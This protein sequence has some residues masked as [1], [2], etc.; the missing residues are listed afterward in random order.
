MAE[1]TVVDLNPIT[2][3]M[4]VYVITTDEPGFVLDVVPQSESLYP[5]IDPTK[6]IVRRPIA[7][8]DGLAYAVTDFFI[9]EVET[10][11]QKNSRMS[12]EVIDREAAI[13]KVQ[14][15]IAPPVNEGRP[16]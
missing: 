1:A 2:P 4:V 15:T 9:Q 6:V 10:M 16:N 12:Q 13:R 5:G 3:G 7:T 11:A 14:A 8:R